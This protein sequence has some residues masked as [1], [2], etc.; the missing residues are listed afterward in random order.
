MMSLL[1]EIHKQVR[2][3]LNDGFTKIDQL[4]DGMNG[5]IK[6]VR[7]SNVIL[8]FCV[9]HTQEPK[10][11][12]K[13]KKEVPFPLKRD[14]LLAFLL[15][16]AQLEYELKQAIE[17]AL[18]SKA[19]KWAN[20]KQSAVNIL[21]E[22]A[23]SFSGSL[24]LSSLQKDENL[25]QWFTNIAN[26]V[27]SIEEVNSV[28]NVQKIFQLSSALEKIMQFHQ[29]S[30][31]IFIKE[32]V[33]RVIYILKFLGRLLNIDEHFLPLIG[34][35]SDFSY[36]FA[37]ISQF[38]PLMQTRIKADPFSVLKLRA[39]FL[40]L[41]SI[42]DLQLVRIV[43]SESKDVESVSQHYSSLIVDFVRT[44]LEIVPISIFA[45]LEKNH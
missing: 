23:L 24:S 36:G 37:S 1:P 6:L 26:E 38:I 15:D 3:V 34:N 31:S 17:A 11:E 30:G 12:K 29:I 2:D 42:L 8:R 45:V 16:V 14:D 40:K 4:L 28:P 22:L 25:Q 18:N 43:Q 35:L 5:Y 32:S 13:K 10:G 21:N 20:E 19:E 7:D 41:T 39:T 9:L 44:V 33:L 27:N